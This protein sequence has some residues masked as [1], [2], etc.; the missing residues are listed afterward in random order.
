MN[1]K[2]FNYVDQVSTFWFFTA[3]AAFFFSLPV[4]A[5]FVGAK[6]NVVIVNTATALPFWLLS[7]WVAEILDRYELRLVALCSAI[8][9]QWVLWW[10]SRYSI[11]SSSN[12]LASPVIHGTSVQSAFELGCIFLLIAITWLAYRRR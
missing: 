2:L 6:F 3:G 7:L 12:F 1:N 8:F 11:Y 9:L 10:P 5:Y 4:I